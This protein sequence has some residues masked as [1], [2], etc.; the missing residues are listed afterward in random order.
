MGTRCFSPPPPAVFPT[1]HCPLLLNCLSPSRENIM[2]RE[3]KMIK[4]LLPTCLLSLRIALATVLTFNDT[5]LWG[6]LCTFC[7]VW[8]VET[9]L[10][11]SSFELPY[12]W[13]FDVGHEV[14]MGSHMVNAA[15]QVNVFALAS[16]SEG[17]FP[18]P[19]WMY[20]QCW[21]DS[22]GTVISCALHTK[23]LLQH[24]NIH[25]PFWI[26]LIN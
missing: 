14:S 16:D 2:E 23:P 9:Y 19:F 5:K 21:A 4:H 13:H 22:S 10:A 18:F 1:Q 17:F 25:L 26:I 24:P 6:K 3:E 7:I 20:G 11:L 15:F 12:L 8:P